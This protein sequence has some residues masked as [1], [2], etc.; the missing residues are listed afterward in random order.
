[1]AS[2]ALL[3]APAALGVGLVADHPEP[4]TAPPPV[5]HHEHAVDLGRLPL[6]SGYLAIPVRASAATP[7]E[8][9]VQGG[10]TT[11]AG[12]VW[13]EGLL[14]GNATTGFA[15]GFGSSAASEVAEAS[16][17]GRAVRCCVAQAPG[18]RLAWSSGGESSI[19]GELQPGEQ[20][21]VLLMANVHAHETTAV[22][23][24]THDVVTLGEP[25]VGT[26]VEAVDLAAAARDATTHVGALGVRVATPGGAAVREWSPEGS[27]FLAMWATAHGDV[28]ARVLVDAPGIGAQE[29]TLRNGYADAYVL[30][31]GAFR[32]ELRDL[33][34][35]L[36]VG[37]LGQHSSLTVTVLF[38]DLP[39]E[40][41]EHRWH[42]G[43]WE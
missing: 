33:D 9:L 37:F 10:N 26:R 28:S 4:A 35:P 8:L 21:L 11:P 23:R 17:E 34:Q 22:L 32:A 42:A 7:F 6:P 25:L 14:F 41:H 40:G 1:L 18:L 38:A 12:P 31:P 15:G 24:T 29:A 19:A 2:L 16:V 13:G 20:W 27:G 3:L 36:A 39:L 5:F 43:T 30:A